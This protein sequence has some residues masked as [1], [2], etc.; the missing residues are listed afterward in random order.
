MDPNFYLLAGL[1]GVALWFVIAYFLIKISVKHA[2]K[3][4]HKELNTKP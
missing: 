4:A 3:E 2:I 1:I